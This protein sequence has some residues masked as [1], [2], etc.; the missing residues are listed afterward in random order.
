MASTIPPTIIICSWHT[1]LP[2]EL[3]P[4]PQAIGMV[5]GQEIEQ[6][7][8]DLVNKWLSWEAASSQTAN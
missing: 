7:T 6:E 2:E 3:Q 1:T 4:L 5:M 8:L